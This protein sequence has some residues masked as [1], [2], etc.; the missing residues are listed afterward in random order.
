MFISGNLVSQV[1]RSGRKIVP[2]LDFWRGERMREVR[3]EVKV[4]KGSRPSA[5][6]HFVNYSKVV[7]H[8]K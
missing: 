6:I 3:G 8:I 7:I 2:P 4:S 5:R 1:T